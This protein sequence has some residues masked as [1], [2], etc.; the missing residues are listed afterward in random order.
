L[1]FH[2]LL[3]A[4]ILRYAYM[5]LLFFLLLFPLLFLGRWVG[6]YLNIDQVL[7][8]P[9]SGRG[10]PFDFYG[11]RYVVQMVTSFFPFPPSAAQ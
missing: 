11:M 4:Q 1:P 9:R 6:S 2:I 7:P 8:V 3:P 10:V 5:R